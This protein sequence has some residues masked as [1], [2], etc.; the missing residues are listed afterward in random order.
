MNEELTYVTGNYGK[1]ISVKE[2][3]EKRNISI[4]YFKC[5]LEELDIN[6]IE[7]ISHKKALDAFNILKSPCFVADTG[8]YIEDYPNNPGYPGAFVKRSNISS[9]ID[10]LLEVMKDK[11]NRKC[12]FV[13]CLTFYDGENFYTFYGTSEGTLSKEKRGNQIK[14][15]KSNLWYV[16]IP[17]NYEKT[18]AEMT[19]EE[20]INRQDKHTSATQ[21]FLEW[22][23]NVYK[24]NK[25]L[26]KII[27]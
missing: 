18:L 2:Y 7:L 16:F 17:N 14:K 13:D 26:K 22:Y 24:K 11:T 1:Y 5:D 12:K 4:N 21:E 23:V 20:R 25:S 6:D 15:A 8:F 3:F 19:D 10:S 27:V 9:D